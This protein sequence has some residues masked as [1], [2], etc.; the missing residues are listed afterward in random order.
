VLLFITVGEP[1]VYCSNCGKEGTGSF[2]QNCGESLAGTPPPPPTDSR[3]TASPR[4][5]PKE[6]KSGDDFK[7]IVAFIIFGIIMVGMLF[8]FLSS[9]LPAPEEDQATGSFKF[10]LIGETR[11]YSA[12]LKSDDLGRTFVNDFYVEKGEEWT[13]SAYFYPVGDYTISFFVDDSHWED[14]VISVREGSTI[15]VEFSH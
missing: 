7:T 6:S 14:R 13:S 1:M 2:C 5:K 8:W 4:N 10:K 9:A 3:P 15:T 11:S 12:T